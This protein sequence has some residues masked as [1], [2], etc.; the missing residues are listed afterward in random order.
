MDRISPTRRPDEPVVMRQRWE[1]LL[2]LHWEADPALLQSL[3]PPGLT[4]DTFEGRAYVGLVPFTMRDVRPVWS[5]PVR[6]LSHFHECNVRTYVHRDGAEPGVWFFS[7]DAANPVAVG[8]A[9]AVWKLPYFFARMSLTERGGETVYAT[10]RVGPDPARAPSGGPVACHVRYAPTGTPRP[11]APG[12]L[13]HFLAE[14][15]ILYAHAGRLLSGRVHHVPY[16]LQTADVYE[17]SDTLIEAAGVPL[18]DGAL[19]P[20]V[21]LAHYAS[22]VSVEVF[23]LRPCA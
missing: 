2:F 18:P 17:L 20:G 7:L 8:I 22:G 11:S 15:Y 16:P 9:R 1:K 12:T 5:P 10:E 6:G 14:R 23:P 21:P 19:R 4:L 13:E 3:L